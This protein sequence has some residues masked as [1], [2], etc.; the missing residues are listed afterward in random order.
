MTEQVN[1]KFAT[2]ETVKHLVRLI[3]TQTIDPSGNELPAILV[4]KG[5]WSTNFVGE[6]FD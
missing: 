1:W 5:T 2:E 4:I 6:V 3:Q